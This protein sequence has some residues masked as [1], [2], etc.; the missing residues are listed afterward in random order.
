MNNN[1]LHPLASLSPSR[2]LTIEEIDHI[3][4]YLR[5]FE[6]DAS[7]VCMSP[8]LSRELQTNKEMLSLF[9]EMKHCLMKS[10]EQEV[11]QEETP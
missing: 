4:G 10:S 11:A 3:L 9:T 6:M 7:D 1:L 2:G 5:Q 8:E